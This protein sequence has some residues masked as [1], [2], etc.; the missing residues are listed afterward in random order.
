MSGLQLILRTIVEENVRKIHE[1][2][3][4][5]YITIIVDKLAMRDKFLAY[6][7]PPSENS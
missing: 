7:P 3:Q 6:K 4:V 5:S 1:L 2:H